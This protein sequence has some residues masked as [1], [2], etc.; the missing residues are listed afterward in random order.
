[1]QGKNAMTAQSNSFTDHALTFREVT[2]E[3]WPDMER[4]FEGHGV[5]D[6]RQLL[7]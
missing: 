5:W 4:L 2:R 1:V 6:G 7:I 3:T